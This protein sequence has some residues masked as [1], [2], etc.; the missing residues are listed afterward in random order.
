MNETYYD[1]LGVSK[2]ASDDELKKAYR[3]L[4]IEYHP[5][6]HP[7]D[8]TAEDR[9][10]KINE[11]YAVLSDKDKRSAYDLSLKRPAGS[12]FASSPKMSVEEVEELFQKM[13]KRSPFDDNS[14]SSY[15]TTT[16]FNETIRE[17]EEDL[18]V[19]VS[20]S[21]SFED[22]YTGCKKMISYSY[23][24]NCEACGGTGY[25]K[26]SKLISCP[27]CEGKGY[28]YTKTNFFGQTMVDKVKC[29][30]CGG[31]GSRRETPCRTCKGTGKKMTV[32]DI[33]VNIPAGAVD[34]MEL[35]APECGSV[36]KS[37][38]KGNLYITIN[39]PSYSS[40]GAFTRTKDQDLEL[41]MELSYYDLMC[42]IDKEIQLPDGSK[43]K[44]HVPEC[45]R[46]GS[47]IRLKGCGFKFLGGPTGQERGDLIINVDLERTGSLTEKQKKL[48]KDFDDSLKR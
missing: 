32:K 47:K 41:N 38:K 8:K 31:A 25:D 45:C 10:K 2:T 4:A 36:S 28:R 29:S 27:Q 33:N 19:R 39:V 48:L 35:R 37:G 24:D 7:G 40:D 12:G 14:F 20:M 6:K 30:Y 43:K 46:P 22:A 34:G 11:A 21:I 3:K 9:F 16:S 44:F 17:P 18:D 26:S 23:K 5:D 1:I 13:F 15:K 42:G